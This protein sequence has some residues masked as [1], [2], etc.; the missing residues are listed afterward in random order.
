MRNAI[1]DGA[2]IIFI[3]FDSAELLSDFRFRL[4]PVHRQLVFQRIAT[5]FAVPSLLVLLESF[6]EIRRLR[7]SIQ[8]SPNPAAAG[9]GSQATYQ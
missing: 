9:F 5:G 2:H 7:N 3:S 4:M 1:T 6:R 8:I